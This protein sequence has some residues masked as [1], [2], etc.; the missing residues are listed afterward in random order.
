MLVDLVLTRLEL[1]DQ[2]LSSLCRDVN[3][4]SGEVGLIIFKL[5]LRQLLV[6]EHL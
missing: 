1:F 6:L 5:L 2:L 3:L 4:V